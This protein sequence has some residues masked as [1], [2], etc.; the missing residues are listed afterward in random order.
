M[1]MYGIVM[2]VLVF[3]ALE[4]WRRME[5]VALRGWSTSRLGLARFGVIGMAAVGLV[6][7][8]GG[9]LW[10][11]SDD[12]RRMVEQERNFY[13][14]LAIKERGV[15]DAAHRPSLT[16][17]RIRHGSQLQLH[18]TWPTTYFGP[19]TG[20]ALAIQHHPRRSEV[21][22]QFRVGVVGLGV[23]TLAAYGNTRVDAELDE[24]LYV[25][26]RE[27]DQPDYMRFYELNPQ[28]TQW[29]ESGPFT[30]IADAKTRGVDVEVFEGDARIVLERQLEMG[31][32]QRFDVLAIDAFSSDAIPIHLLTLEAVEMYL[33][34]LQEDGILAF[35][36]TNRFVDLLP[37]V[38]RHADATGMSAIYIEN[39][40]SSRRQ[41]DSADWVLLTRNQSF[42]DLEIVRED[43][44]EM[45]AAGPLWTDDF[46][47]LFEVVEF[48]D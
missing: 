24:E 32:A 47:S 37:V 27:T 41:V 23:G 26:Q 25:T 10:Q 43:E 5:G 9:L 33:G 18:P 16:H 39:Y 35:N 3:V 20:I 44:V 45:P 14:T 28:V 29:A 4:V 42:L 21:A 6:S 30:Y 19:E 11:V 1:A 7:L 31:E 38:Q 34:H 15:G 17:G 40:S 2:A 46:S 36:V 12:E 13:G 48:D 8:S 22:R